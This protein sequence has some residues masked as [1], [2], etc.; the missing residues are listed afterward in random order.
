MSRNLKCVMLVDD[1]QNDNFY[2]EREIKKCNPDILVIE[3]NTGSDALEYLKA[4]LDSEDSLPNLIFLDINM[5]IL[6]GWEF[7]DAYEKL[8]KKLQGGVIIIMLSTS[9]NIEDIEKARTYKC[10]AD[11]LT[12]P[13]TRE[14]MAEIQKKYFNGQQ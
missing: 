5:P 9:G 10:V 3:K 11:Y 2:H 4:N 12:K 8:D 14:L 13:L 1:D 6:N 7:L